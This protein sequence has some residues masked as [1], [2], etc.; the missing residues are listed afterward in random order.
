M[1]NNSKRNHN[2]VLMEKLA[3][4]IRMLRAERGW[5]Q[6]TTSELAGL[7]RNYF[8]YIERSEVNISL[9]QLEKIATAFGMTLHE[10]INF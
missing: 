3:S 1:K 6:E 8:G 5:S 7:H 9:C 2:P 10:L 4:R